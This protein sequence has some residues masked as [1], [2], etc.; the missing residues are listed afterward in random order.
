M[1]IGGFKVDFKKTPL[2]G[3]K[4]F[5]TSPA[6]N[7]RGPHLNTVKPVQLCEPQSDLIPLVLGFAVGSNLGVVQV[8]K[9][10]PNHRPKTT[11]HKA[12]NRS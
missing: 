9:S 10:S 12:K 3:L 4:A 1:L 2:S 5:E 7:R 11:E 6:H 8:A